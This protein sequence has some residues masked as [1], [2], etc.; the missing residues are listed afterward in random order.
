MNIQSERL[1]ITH[2]QPGMAKR[3][4]EL[5]LD[6]NNRRFVPDEVFETEKAAAE[7]IAELTECIEQQEGP[8]V[9]AVLLKDGTL[10]GHVQAVPL[11][12]GWEIGYHIGQPYT[13]CGYATEAVQSFLPEIMNSLHITE[14]LGVCLSANTASARVMEKC[15][16]VKTFEGMDDYQGTPSPVSKYIYK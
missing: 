13:G 11:K 5:S 3:L 10:I 4:H 12:E 6:E 9:Y 15:G 7:V 16:F 8:Q 14:M 2:L 1:Q